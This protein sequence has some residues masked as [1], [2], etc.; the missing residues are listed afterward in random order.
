MDLAIV[1]VKATEVHE[2][3]WEQGGEK[4]C[5]LD[6]ILDI[7]WEKKEVSPKRSTCNTFYLNFEN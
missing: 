6:P 5:I 3:E 7:M 1:R 4:S 2:G